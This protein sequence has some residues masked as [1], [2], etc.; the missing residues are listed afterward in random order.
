MSD[1]T[2]NLD[3]RNQVFTT[4]DGGEADALT[5]V[6][7][8]TLEFKL[9]IF[10]QTSGSPKPVNNLF[11]RTMVMVLGRTMAPPA[12]GKFRLKVDGTLKAALNFDASVAD[13]LSALGAAEGLAPI[14]GCWLVRFAD[15]DAVITPA[16]DTDADANTL[17]P[18]SFIRLR[19]ALRNTVPWW[20][21]RLINTPFAIASTYDTELAPPPAITRLRAGSPGGVGVAP[22]NEIQRLR[23]PNLFVGTFDVKFGLRRSELM[24]DQDGPDEIA[25]ALNGM[26]S[27]GK[28]RFKVTNL[29]EEFANIE[30]VG[31][32]EEASQE[33]MV[34]S[35]RSFAPAAPVMVLECDKEP[36][37]DAMRT[38]GKIE[39]VPFELEMNV[40]DNADDIDNGAIK[41]RFITFQMTATCVAEQKFEE[42]TDIPT[43][44]WATPPLA[45]S[46]VPFDPAMVIT[47]SQ[48]YA[49]VFGDNVHTVFAFNHVLGQA[50]AIHAIRENIDNGRVLQN[51]GE[52]EL[53]LQAN[54][55]NLEMSFVPTSNELIFMLSTYGPISAFAA[56]THVIDAIT[57]LR[58]ELD[59]IEAAITAIQDV[60][61]FT[62]PGVL[63]ESTTGGLQIKV[64]EKK[65]IYPGRFDAAYDPLSGKAPKRVFALYPALHT[66]AAA[67]AAS[68]IPPTPV[69]ST[70]YQNT[71]GGALLIPGAYGWK[72]ESVENNGYF[73]TDGRGLYVLQKSGSSNSY[74]PRQMEES[75]FSFAV[76]SDMLLASQTL[77]FTFDIDTQLFGN[78]TDLSMEIVVE[79]GTV[80]SEGT[81]S[82]TEP[83]LQNVVWDVDH[84]ILKKKVVM[85]DLLMSY[86]FGAAIKVSSLGVLSADAFIYTKWIASANAPAAA[87]FV[88]RARLIN[89]DTEN[90]KVQPKGALFY[91][92][93]SFT[94]NIA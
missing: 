20:E 79:F 84:P 42:L 2:L 15:P 65:R 85:T 93:N 70:L 47:G 33:L 14:A 13:V 81:P 74:F 34:V 80:P 73:T 9:N 16:L 58:D 7:G 72:S 36:F 75:L 90:A 52:Y 3:Y 1:R 45:K 17:F 50:T 43:I 82:P 78:T 10:D 64:P 53:K 92:M 12:T 63:V 69:A 59:A 27:D 62:T 19:K 32:L 11:I 87:N 8:D 60:L 38:V 48:H 25:A 88:L 31:D 37:Y 39:E 55:A 23:V 66:D 46:Y 40:V 21:I 30:F 41:G 49:A 94:V 61:P 86:T 54:T 91:H 6:L 18:V 56:H 35:V 24:S 4:A 26:Y 29:E 22:T 89:A 5:I 71:S 68:V 57:G 83:N 76:D 51:G 44:N 77:R 28:V 67:T